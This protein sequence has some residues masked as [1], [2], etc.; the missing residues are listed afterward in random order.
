MK[1]R[2]HFDPGKILFFV[3]QILESSL[4]SLENHADKVLLNGQRKKSRSKKQFLTH[5]PDYDNSFDSDDAPKDQSDLTSK[6]SAELDNIRDD[7]DQELD[8][9]SQ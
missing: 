3:E 5:L 4:I 2:T 6:R 9:E 7:S 1:N 8:L